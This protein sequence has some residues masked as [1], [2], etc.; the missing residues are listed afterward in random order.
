M[1]PPRRWIFQQWSWNL[2]S[3]PTQIFLDFL[4]LTFTLHDKKLSLIQL[5]HSRS[6]PLLLKINNITKFSR[7]CIAYRLLSQVRMLLFTMEQG[8]HPILI[9]KSQ[10]PQHHRN[11]LKIQVLHKE[12]LLMPLSLPLL[13]LRHYPL[14]VTPS[15][16]PPRPPPFSLFL[17]L[18]ICFRLHL[19]TTNISGNKHASRSSTYKYS[20]KAKTCSRPPWNQTI[21]EEGL[22]LSSQ[23]YTLL[24]EGQRLVTSKYKSLLGICIVSQKQFHSWFLLIC[25]QPN[26]LAR[27]CSQETKDRSRQSSQ[28]RAK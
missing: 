25:R 26:G 12:Q 6:S 20:Q 28:I 27:K 17:H 11:L 8:S 4:G 22:V 10:S 16:P 13:L 19:R 21:L 2:S 5:K 14:L 18:T 15:P 7:H 3:R 9:D 23:L 24:H 1:T